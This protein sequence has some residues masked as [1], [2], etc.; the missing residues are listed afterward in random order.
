M[1]PATAQWKEMKNRAGLRL[2]E[3]GLNKEKSKR[4]IDD[5]DAQRGGSTLELSA[6][7]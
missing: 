2:T 4:R 5:D 1:Q 7:A 3:T 6:A